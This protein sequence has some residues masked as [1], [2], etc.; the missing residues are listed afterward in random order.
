MALES[1]LQERLILDA[2]CTAPYQ[3]PLLCSMDSRE[4]FF[5]NESCCKSW[6]LVLEYHQGAIDV[7]SLLESE[8]QTRKSDILAVANTRQRTTT[9]AIKAR[10]TR[11]DLGLFPACMLCTRYCG[12]TSSSP[13]MHI[14]R[15]RVVSLPKDKDGLCIT[16]VF[17]GI[18][19]VIQA[20]CWDV[21]RSSVARILP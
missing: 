14:Q 12:N 15:R 11:T 10:W 16:V 6:R 4:A 2:T 3:L 21:N 18:S 1:W 19:T 8:D 20:G 5:W 9:S 7:R 17:S 13:Q